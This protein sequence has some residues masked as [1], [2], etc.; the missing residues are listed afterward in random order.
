MAIDCLSGEAQ[1]Q[2]R[3]NM[4][5]GIKS[6]SS[7][8]VV[9]PPRRFRIA[10]SFTGERRTFVKALVDVLLKQFGK[11]QILYDEFHKAEFAR[12][13]LVTYL[14]KLYRDQADLIVVVVCDKY[15]VKRWTGM[16]WRHIHSMLMDKQDARIMLC[17]FNHATVDG[18]T[19]GAGFAAMDHETPESAAKQVLERLAMVEGREPSFYIEPKPKLKNR[20]LK[21]SPTPSITRPPALLAVPA[22]IGSH[23]FIGRT[24]ELQTIDDWAN[25]ADT[26]AVLLF[27]AIGGNG[28][29]ML[30]WHWVKDH[31][32]TVRKDW[33]GQFWYSFYE[34]GTTM[35]GFARHALA[36][37]TGVAPE[38]LNKLRMPE[39]SE[40][41]LA[42][43]K[44]KPY[45]LIL[46]GLERALVAYNRFDAATMADEEAD[47]ATDQIGNR[48]PCDATNPDDDVF[49]RALATVQPT[50]VLVTSR[51]T[52]RVLIN[53]ASQPV[54]GVRRE[55]LGGLRPVDAEAMLKAQGVKG[56]AEAMRE[57]LVKNCACHPLVIGAIA[58]L[59][60]N[61]MPKRGD[62][63]AWVNDGSELG[64]GRLNLA[65]LDLKQKKNHILRAA[66]ADTPEAGRKL[67]K[68]LS[69]VHSGVDYDLLKALNPHLPPKPTEV[70]EPKKPEQDWRWQ[71]LTE[72][73]R[74]KLIDA[75]P[76]KV[77]RYQAYQ[78]AVQTR[79][80][81]KAYLSAE[82][83]LSATLQDLLQRGLLQY[84]ANRYDL[85]PVVRGVARGDLKTEEKNEFGQS[86][87]D[88]FSAREH[89]PYEHA[90]TLED[91][92]D[93][94]QLVRTQIEM[95]RMRQAT[96]A[97]RGD[98]AVALSSNLE[99]YTEALALLKPFFPGGWDAQPAGID[100]DDAW[101]LM[102][103]AFITLAE[104]G[105]QDA[106]WPIVEPLVRIN[107]SSEVWSEVRNTITN[108]MVTLRGQNRLRASLRCGTLALDLATALNESED[109]FIAKLSLFDTI[110]ALGQYAQAQAMWDEL[111]PMG[112]DWQRAQY[113]PGRAEQ[114]YAKFRFVKGDVTE[115]H[116]QKAL[117]LAT[118]GCNR[119]T[120][121]RGHALRGQWRAE[122][123]EWGLAAESLTEAV[124]MAREVRQVDAWSETFL[125]L[126]NHHRGVLHDSRIEAQRLATL[127]DPAHRPLAELY[128][129]LGD[130]ALATKHALAAYTWAWADGE[131]YVHRAELT[132]SA[133]LLK[134]LGEP[135]PTLP[136]FDES[137][138]LPFEWEAD[139]RAAIEKIKIEKADAEQA[140]EKATEEVK[141]AEGEKEKP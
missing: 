60:N 61:Y 9:T 32:N 98:L 73:E 40:R 46:D 124:R 132:K 19:E 89:N 94:L 139:V 71:R 122:R 69:L 119:V 117:D 63:D 118:K 50:K 84:D 78:Q 4:A 129:A 36:Y 1:V 77:K 68:K 97:Y 31:A 43:L 116:W 107:L 3:V 135:I 75:Y 13:D 120:I 45:L 2:E 48:N 82:K 85:H 134:R 141:K 10:F 62:F 52:P 103:D 121:R 8:V 87:V 126:A 131:P 113:R 58:G 81:S 125:I 27:E 101:Y 51:L 91:L 54:P 59:I 34:R 20:G 33:A 23:S 76:A 18:L 106:A 110:S 86:V 55:F 15:D 30:T 21:A 88:Y 72:E 80:A 109:I 53:N 41:L 79:L 140:A 16:E 67:L 104:L 64:G 138:H 70:E 90:Q 133:D 26:H 35:E 96:V 136:P 22:Y 38:T 114:A 44:A 83:N 28:K 37:V 56:D 11:E 65:E 29:S 6:G 128:L 130:R 108:T 111:D 102:N 105:M 127:P 99:A 100:S 137:K 7:P 24:S 123:G 42:H 95:G 66:I 14:P 17:N 112:R 25:P 115:D 47:T 39:L 49:L 74:S 5:R 57:Y 92:A 12:A 93:G